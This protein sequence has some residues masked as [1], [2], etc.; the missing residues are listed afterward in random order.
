MKSEK[1]E[2]NNR[3]AST[4][5]TLPRFSIVNDCVYARCCKVPSQSS[6][7]ADFDLK[8]RIVEKNLLK[9]VPPSLDT[10]VIQKT[11][12]LAERLVG[13]REL[14]SPKNRKNATIRSRDELIAKE[15]NETTVLRQMSEITVKFFQ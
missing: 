2:W 11:K 15:I 9:P 12:L 8:K 7:K 6:S 13:S 4:T 3:V 10:W 5:E 14:R 1:Y